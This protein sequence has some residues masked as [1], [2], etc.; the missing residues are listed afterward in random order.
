MAKEVIF[1]LKVNGTDEVN[2]SL[3]QVNKTIDSISN[4]TTGLAGKGFDD[5]SKGANN[6]ANSIER[7]NVV[8][9]Q[10]NDFARK[11]D[12]VQ[13]TLAGS[14][15]IVTSGLKQFGIQNEV[16]T[17]T[18]ERVQLAAQF[19]SGLREL[20]EGFKVL[21]ETVNLSSFSFKGLTA[22]IAANPIGALVTVIAIVVTNFELL[23]DVLGVVVGAFKSAGEAIGQF[24]GLIE[25]TDEE[26]KKVTETTYGWETALASLQA[27]QAKTNKEA[28]RDLNL[29][30][31]QG[32]STNEVELATIALNKSKLEQAKAN[33][34]LLRQQQ[35][36]LAQDA[37][38]VVK[39]LE[40]SKAIEDQ[41]ELIKDADNQVKISEAERTQRQKDD[42]KK[43]RDDANKA[44]EEQKQKDAKALA[45]LRETQ[46]ARLDAIAD[47]A[48]EELILIKEKAVGRE[49]ADLFIAE[50]SLLLEERTN[51][52]RV[53]LLNT[54]QT[55]LD[56]IQEKRKVD[57]T[58][59]EEEVSDNIRQIRAKNADIDIQQAKALA[60]KQKKA[61]EEEAKKRAQERTDL[62]TQVES[63]YQ[64]KRGELINSFNDKEKFA[65]EKLSLDLQRIEIEKQQKLLEFYEA[66]SAEFIK[67]QADI[68]DKQKKLNEDSAKLEKTQLDDRINYLKTTLTDISN[69]TKDLGSGINNLGQDI[70]NGFSTIGANIPAL[71]EVINKEYDTIEQR[72]AAIANAAIGFGS[73]AVSVLGDILSKET[74]RQTDELE[75]NT[76]KQLE[77]LQQQKDAGL[78]TEQQLAVGTDKIRKD[79]AKKK[80]ELEKKAFEQ[81]KAIRITQAVLQTAQAVISAFSSGVSTPLIGPAVGAVFA[82]IAAAFGAVQIG[83]IAAQQ[84][85]GDTGGGGGSASAPSVPSVSTP[86]LNASGTLTP[87]TFEPQTFGTNFQQEETF[88]GGGT[89]APVLR[90]Y[91]VESDITATQNRLDGIR[92]TSEL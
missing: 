12:G 32:A 39:Y 53:E 17:K 56:N 77:I 36:L 26:T 45:D 34:V 28:E 22:A 37:T 68:A 73:S 11:A 33:L 55:E 62:L 7:V 89:T 3:N 52:K 16:V 71:F 91:V 6:A 38:Q 54:F 87:T 60:E 66:G 29:L 92:N 58:Q 35:A 10:N 65:A 9:T 30:K 24:L 41:V 61:D 31:A 74:K 2:N 20:S 13:K 43:V 72:T 81:E 50:Q 25:D 5:V 8:L 1:N 18:L 86:S 59:A 75:A 19:A 21:K 67:I 82:G 46:K 85:P 80:L 63:D 70:L 14:I 51:Q 57:T 78:I 40:I 83:L 23:G 15:N 4:K 47:A 42:A 84:F 79:A 48:E 69:L 44:A 76:Q 64:L 88:G 49:D 90:A 27:Q